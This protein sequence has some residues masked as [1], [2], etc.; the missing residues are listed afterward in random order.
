MGGVAEW[1]VDGVNALLVPSND[2]SALAEA[3]RRCL[4][5]PELTSSLGKEARHTFLENFTL[6][7]LGECFTALIER[8][9]IRKES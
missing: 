6:D 1:L 8:V 9:R 2:A 7:R 3:L 5:E 4:E